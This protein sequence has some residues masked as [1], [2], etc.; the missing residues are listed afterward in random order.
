MGLSQKLVSHD[1]EFN[2]IPH[3]VIIL[4]DID[5][6]VPV[7]THI[8]A[9]FQGDVL[10]SVPSCNCQALQGATLLGVTCDICKVKVLPATDKE[11]H[12]LCWMRAPNKTLR[13]VNPIIWMILKD[14]TGTGTGGVPL[15]TFLTDPRL[16]INTYNVTQQFR[17]VQNLIAEGTLVRG[18]TWFV[19]NFRHVVE[20]LTKHRLLSK[21]TVGNRKALYDFLVN[22]SDEELFCNMLPL[23]SKLSFI[24]EDAGRYQITDKWQIHAI[25]AVNTLRDITGHENTRV[26]TLEARMTKLMNHMGTFYTQYIKEVLMSKSGLI[27]K[28]VIAS[29]NSYSFRGVITSLTNVHRYDEIHIPWEIAVNVLQLH[30]TNKLWARG[31]TWMQARDLIS[32]SYVQ[33]NEV[34]DDI[35][36][37]LIEETPYGYGISVIVVRNP[38]LERG[39]VLLSY[40]TKV[41]TNPRDRTIG[42]SILNITSLNADF[43]G[44]AINFMLVPSTDLVDGLKPMEA[45]NG[46]LDLAKPKSMN[47]NAQ[48]PAPLISSINNRL[49]RARGLKH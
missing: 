46:I 34:I 36:K 6:D 47:K 4:N 23:P 16:R 14:N 1:K 11:I 18:Y 44:D 21:G 15:L 12:S 25:E 17:K 30:I 49:D 26:P 5:P 42:I 32:A 41:K 20:V 7:A 19:D 10:D 27:R 40:I 3:P 39:S 33:Y 13:F 37:E 31:Y 24:T 28:H 38:S 48:L 43:D 45:H 9:I 35:F 29:R 22:A 8:R 2:S